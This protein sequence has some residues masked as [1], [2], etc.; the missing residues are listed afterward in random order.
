MNTHRFVA[1]VLAVLTALVSP[2]HS[3]QPQPKDTLTLVSIVPS[4]AVRADSEVEFTVEVDVTL[5]TSDEAWLHLGFNVEE[6]NRYR[7]VSQ[8]LLYRGMERVVIKGKAVPRNYGR[9]GEFA[10]M[11]NIGPRKEGSYSPTGSVR[12]V[13]PVVP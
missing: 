12:R 13:I 4:G 9:T 1:T 6:P 8:Y 10:V 11:L 2:A 3:A 5:E 7:M